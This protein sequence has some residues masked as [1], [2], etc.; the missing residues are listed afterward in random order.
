MSQ[1][2]NPF[3]GL[4]PAEVALE[5]RTSV[6]AILSLVF[7]ILCVPGFGVLG[8]L[9]GVVALIVIANAAGRL[10][11]RGLAIAGLVIS[12]LVSVVWAAII[13]GGYQLG[14][15]LTGALGKSATAVLTSAESG[16]YATARAE[17]TSAA[18]AAITDDDFKQW[19]AAYQAEVGAF[20]RVPQGTIEFIMSYGNI[21][22][23]I[24]KF[25]QGQDLI[26]VPCE[27][28][29]GWAL[30]V[31]QP[32]QRGGQA[33]TRIPVMNVGVYSVSGKKYWL[34]NPT[35]TIPPAPGEVEPAEGETPPTEPEP[36]PSTPDE[37]EVPKP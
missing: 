15:T 5:Q 9:L 33:G 24:S 25:Q 37:P 26:P 22:P 27:F 4:P 11:G 14:K 6:L 19:V 29:K 10:S 32:D 18:Q 16:D 20:K 17:L 23:I 2:S 12:L 8:A 35:P 31:F 3:S 30:V 13:I 7:G 36:R 21:G 34:Y 1:S 28:E